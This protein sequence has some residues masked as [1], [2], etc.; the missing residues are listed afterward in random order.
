[1]TQG[2][3]LAL[4][5]VSLLD[6]VEIYGSDI[7]SVSHLITTRCVG[8]LLGSLLGGK[9][10]DTYNVQTMSILTMAIACVTVFMI[11][12]SGSLPLAHVMVFFGGISFGAFDTGANVWIIKLWPQNS[13][14][15]L[16]V[17]HLAFGVGCLVAPLFAEPFLST[18]HYATS[19]LNLTDS[20]DTAFEGLFFSV[21]GVALLDL[22]DVYGTDVG[23]VAQL[24]TTRGVGI[25]AGSFFGG[26]LYD[27]LNTQ[28]LSVLFT[29]LTSASV[30][31]TPSSGELLYAHGTSV[32]AGFSMGALDTG[33]NVWLINLW[34]SGCGPVL[35]VYHL[36]F[37]VGAFIAP[38]VAEP[39]LSCNTSVT[40]NTTRHGGLLIGAGTLSREPQLP[41]AFGIVS[42]FIALVA[43]SMF[44]V[45][46]VDRSDC[47]PSGGEQSSQ[48][49]NLVLVGLL[50]CY[51]MA[52]L[53]LECSY[54][55]MLATFA[56]ESD[57]RMTK[58]EAAYLTSLYFLTF[59]VARIGSVL[60]SMLAGP[61]CIL[62]TCQLLTAVI[63]TLLVVFGDSSATWLWT[64][65]GLAGVSLAAIFAAAVSYT[66]QFVVMTNRLMSMVTVAASLGTMVPP[67]FVGLFIEKDP[68]M[69]TY[70]CLA[71]ALI[72]SAFCFAMYLV[73]R[74]RPLVTADIS[75]TQGGHVG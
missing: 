67:L 49:V 27:R 28:L 32:L 22:A 51:I 75:E 31:V 58:S 16:Q 37:G 12:L 10:Y 73:T 13:S 17:F 63:F 44:V 61:S 62:I 70:V 9:L 56:V 1:M 26:L 34:P 64:L 29:A 42:G 74:G 20:N 14:P 59:T 46:L 47:K 7:S 50:G 30:F 15:A 3:I 5:G 40:A 33:A 71:T 68:M 39:F 69:F 72:M 45:Y 65:S 36:A 19:S 23:S 48:P 4:T 25:L 11:P 57:L 55:Q 35:Q 41:F 66:V 38:F 24:V 54:G 21:T 18:G 53:G 8:G 2:L 43:T 60:W 52:Y 6:L